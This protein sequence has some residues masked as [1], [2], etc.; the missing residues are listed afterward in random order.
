MII[1]IFSKI[2]SIPYKLLIRIPYFKFIRETQY[3]QTPITLKIWFFQKVLGFNKK[4]YWPMHFTSKI[5]GIENVLCGIETCPGYMPGCYI[6]GAGKIYIGNY[7]QIAANVGIITANHNIYENNKNDESKNVNIGKYSWIGFSSVILPGVILGDYT[8][9]GA[10]SIVTKSFPEGYVVI[11]GNPAKI[12]R[13]LDEKLVK[14]FK[15]EY[16]YNGYIKA[17]LFENYRKTNLQV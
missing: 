5:H 9:V 8:I 2:I 7:T 16:E 17:E 3:T 4:A 13:H 6:Q 10:G 14:P 1:N 11:A 12:I 15:S